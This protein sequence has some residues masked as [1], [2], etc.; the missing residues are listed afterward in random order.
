[1]AAAGDTSVT[2]I[3]KYGKV[4]SAKFPALTIGS[5]VYLSDTAGELV[6]AQPSTTNFAIRK[7]GEAITAE[8]LFFNPS[9]D[10]IIHI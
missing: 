2:K 6:V 10:Y 5:A 9:E 1:L 7:V 3:L 8:D 4:R